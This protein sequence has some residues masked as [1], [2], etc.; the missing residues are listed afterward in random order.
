MGTFCYVLYS[1]DYFFHIS[2]VKPFHHFTMTDRE[3]YL[4]GIVCDFNMSKTIP[5][6]EVL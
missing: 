6:P 5:V 3:L 2:T 1:F 4:W